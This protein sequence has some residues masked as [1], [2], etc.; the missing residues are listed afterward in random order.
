MLNIKSHV[1]SSPNLGQVLGQSFPDCTAKKYAEAR[2]GDHGF[3]SPRVILQ[4]ATAMHLY[5]LV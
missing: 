5:T 4:R 3:V 1:K 2:R